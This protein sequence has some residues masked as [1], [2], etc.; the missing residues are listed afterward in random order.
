[1]SRYYEEC[2]FLRDGISFEEQGFVK[3]FRWVQV[4]QR[5]DPMVLTRFT[6]SLVIGIQ[7]TRVT[8]NVNLRGG[9]KLTY[10]IFLLVF[11]VRSLRLT[12]ERV[13][14]MKERSPRPFEEKSGRS[15]REWVVC[16]LR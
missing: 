1:M 3:F 9:V 6:K 2:R 7:F 5:G 4:Y 16:K 11:F 8:E 10:L 12:K 14:K 13:W 15:F